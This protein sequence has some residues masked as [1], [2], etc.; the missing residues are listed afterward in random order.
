MSFALPDLVYGIIAVIVLIAVIKFLLK[1]TIKK[2][3]KIIIILAVLGLIFGGWAG[4]N[5]SDIKNKV[6][7][8]ISAEYSYSD[9]NFRYL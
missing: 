4:L 9:D 3:V 2:I 8:K 1:S 5:L 7:D 6:D